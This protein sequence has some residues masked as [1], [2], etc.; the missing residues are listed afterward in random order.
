MVCAMIVIIL[1]IHNLSVLAL[2]AFNLEV[3]LCWVPK[4]EC[5]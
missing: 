1:S 5:N 4:E 3:H 2:D